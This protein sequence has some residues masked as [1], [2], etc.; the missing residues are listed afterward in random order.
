MCLSIKVFI[1]MYDFGLFTRQGVLGS[2]AEDDSGDDTDDAHRLADGLI[3]WGSEDNQGKAK[4][5]DS[6]GGIE[7][8]WEVFHGG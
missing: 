6:Q 3:F 2:G 5:E 8:V 7:D 4:E 1:N